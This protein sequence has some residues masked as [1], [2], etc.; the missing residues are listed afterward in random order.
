MNLLPLFAL[1]A[2]LVGLDALVVVPLAPAMAADLGLHTAHAG[3]LVTAYSL[4]YTLGAPL[5][6]PLADRRGRVPVLQA[7]LA[8]FTIATAALALAADAATG[9]LLRGLAGLGAAAITPTL[10]ALLGDSVPTERRGGATGLVYGAMISATV[11]GVPVGSLVADLA[12]WPWTFAGVA[13]AGMATLILV[14]GLARRL[15]PAP[16]VATSRFV[17]TLAAATADGNVRRALMTTLLWYAALYGLFANVGL[18]YSARFGLGTAHIGLIILVAGAASVVGNILGGRL[19]D[20]LTPLPVLGLAALC[21]GAAVLAFANLDGR[22]LHAVLGH[23]AWA[24]LVGLGSAP[25]MALVTGLRSAERA[26]VLALNSSAMY[27]GMSLASGLAA[28]LLDVW[29]Y[30]F[31]GAL[32]A[33]A[34]LGVV[35]LARRLAP[36]TA[37]NT[38]GSTS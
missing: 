37:E 30:P 22:L 25:L 33:T 5:F 16:P 27:L 38:A 29:S 12:R 34:Y 10:F 31:I 4:A 24:F 17:P 18:L 8:L 7:G 14:S 1:C 35:L 3:W 19:A 15:E 21:A 20:R 36:A 28:R 2:F 32:C 23:T 13:V 26:T 6:G 9:L 11:L